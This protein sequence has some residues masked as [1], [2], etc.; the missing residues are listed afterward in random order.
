MSNNCTTVFCDFVTLL[1]EE[2]KPNIRSNF[3]KENSHGNLGKQYVGIK[4]HSFKF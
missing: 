2:N 4:L 1:Q 3:G